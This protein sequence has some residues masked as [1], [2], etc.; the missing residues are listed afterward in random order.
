MWI[1]SYGVTVQMK[2]LQQ[3]FDMVLY[4][5]SILQDEIWDSSWIFIL[6]TLGSERLKLVT[7]GPLLNLTCQNAFSS[8]YFQ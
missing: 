1:K 4:D 3:Y 5:V 8:P 7:G 2:P 6:G